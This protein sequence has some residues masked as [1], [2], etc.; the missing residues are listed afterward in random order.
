MVFDVIFNTNRIINECCHMLHYSS[1][2]MSSL[3]KRILNLQAWWSDSKIL[4]VNLSSLYNLY[5]V[6]KSFYNPQKFGLV[7]ELPQSNK[8]AISTMYPP[9]HIT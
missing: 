1:S 4:F 6:L 3:I 2:L 5:K 9:L 7:Q 8:H